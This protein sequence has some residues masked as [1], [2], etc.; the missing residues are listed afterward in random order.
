L[1]LGRPSLA[2]VVQADRA[3]PDREWTDVASVVE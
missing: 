3:W 1:A 2:K